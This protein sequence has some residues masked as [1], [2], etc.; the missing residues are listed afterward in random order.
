MTSSASPTTPEGRYLGRLRAV[1][2]FAVVAG[3]GGSVGLTLRAEVRAPASC[4]CFFVNR[5]SSGNGSGSFVTQ[6]W[7][8][9]CG[10]R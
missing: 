1:A 6:F 10:L 5:S 2:Q 7:S 3:A 4:W 8:S 9:F